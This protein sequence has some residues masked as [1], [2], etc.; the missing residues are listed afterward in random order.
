MKTYKKILAYTLGS[1]TLLGGGGMLYLTKTG[2]GFEWVLDRMYDREFPDVPSIRPDELAAELAGAR[3]PLLLDTRAPEE[4]AVSHLRDAFFI[5]PQT[6]VSDD[7]DD[8]DRDREI[9]V[10]CSVGYRSAVI[11]RRLQT[12]GF[13]RV[14]NLF[15][16]IF[17]WYNQG[18]P[19]YS[20]STK[21]ERI[22]PYNWFW[23]QF[24]TRS[25]KTTDPESRDTIAK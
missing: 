3:P 21:V 6:F 5:N 9:V 23:G 15:G 4:Y 25:G 20:D 14:R 10:Y 13:T 8:I 7:V 2:R 18:R 24:V 16:G 17:L 22:H 11:V 19:V 12:L 1:V